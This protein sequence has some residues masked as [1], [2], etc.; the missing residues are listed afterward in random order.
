MRHFIIT[1]LILLS[2]CLHAQ[3]QPT[4]EQA[5]HDAQNGDPDA[6]FWLGSSYMNGE[7]V[8]CN[9]TEAIKWLK[10]AADN[11]MPLAYNQLGHCYYR[12]ENYQEAIVWYKKAIDDM[13]F[14]SNR[15]LSNTTC[16]LL[17]SC[18]Y[19][20]KNYQEAIIWLKK[21]IENGDTDS[22]FWLGRCYSVQQNYQ[23]AIIWYK[24]AVENG[25][26]NLY[27]YLGEC[28]F[29]QQNY[30][31]AITWL[32]KAAANGD[33]RVCGYIGTSY[34]NSKNYR[35]AI[36]WLK[37]ALDNGDTHAY[38]GLGKCYFEQ[39]NYQEAYKCAKI[40]VD[41]GIESASFLMGIMLYYGHGVQQDYNQ[42]FK[43]LKM[44]AG[45]GA[46]NAYD[47]LASMYAFGQGTAQNPTEA[48][49]CAK[50]A[51]DNGIITSYFKVGTMYSNGEGVEQNDQEA[52][53]WIKKAAEAKDP[54]SYGALG[55]MY[56][57]GIG[58][59]IDLKEAYRIAK[60]GAEYED[61]EAMA[62]LAR[63][64]REGKGVSKSLIDS[65]EW[66]KKAAEKGFVSSFIWL[67]VMYEDGLGTSKDVNE[68]ITWYKKANDND[69]PNAPMMLCQA[70]YTQ[71]DYVEAKKWA[72]KTINQKEYALV[73]YRILALL[74]MYGLGIPQNKNKAFELIAKAIDEAKQKGVPM[75]N[76]L[77]A[78]GELYLADNNISKAR[79]IYNAISKDTPDFYT[80]KETKL[81]KFMKENKGGDVDFDIPIADN[82][83]NHTFAVII[84]NEKYQME[85][86]VQYAENDGK[87]FTEYCKK[88]LG[89]PEK[90]VHFIT[91]A[92][93]NNIKHEIKW[94]QD[95][96]AVYKGEAKAIFYYAG[97]GIPDEQNKSAY[98]LPIDGYGSDV[99][100]GYAL[101]DL[102]KA[103]G[104]L[105]S[106][107]VTVFLDA[108]F[109]GAKRDG[110]M[111]ASA[112]GV[113]IKVKQATP[114]GNIVVFSAAQGDETAYPYKEEEHG[115]FTYYL[116]KKL[117]ETKG[118]VTLGELSDYIKTQ[119]ERQSIVINGK[120]QSPSFVSTATIANSWKKWTLK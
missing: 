27:G 13:Y 105:P 100:T 108:C 79:E 95:V 119:V 9:Y 48:F 92:T 24:K 106:K 26:T 88:T 21:A 40:A 103:L 16:C 102:Y 78:E 110:D 70:Y 47:I 98:L 4:F 36:L 5:L 14:Y 34:M 91:N 31:E 53:K 54:Y 57:Q 59:A 120:L 8:T 58:T 115:L 12:L 46:Y 74:N 32:K 82:V 17:G 86:S 76:T 61:P 83:S 84:S 77:D 25:D 52:Y 43:W 72:D 19:H 80:Q 6:S 71:E 117:Q 63:M 20:L 30:Q 10:K 44:A 118:N 1:I 65:F 49:K 11:K 96:I 39:Q 87:M 85:K 113:A 107:S 111:L 42:A 66:Q 73:G 81:S 112:R 97:H 101:E 93:L 104:S 28:Y 94:L 35:E 90:N 69:V 75:P 109:S 33:M 41:N 38:L 37:K 15:T 50:I 56:Y 67:G 23:E 3:N 68:A 89:L 7:G 18:Y 64:Y 55:I 116:L 99:T 22:Y 29:Q 51:A 60:I 62:L 45:Y 114:V 2:P